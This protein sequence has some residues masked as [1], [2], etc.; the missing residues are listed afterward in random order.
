MDKTSC[1]NLGNLIST[2]LIII[3]VSLFSYSISISVF[4][5]LLSNLNMLISFM[6]L[7][8]SL[9]VFMSDPGY[10]TDLDLK[11]LLK[12]QSR[13]SGFSYN[14]CETC[15]VNKDD[16]TVHCTQCSKCVKG[17]HHHCAMLSNCIGSENKRIFKLL[18]VSAHV[19]AVIMIIQSVVGL[20]DGHWNFGYLLVI[21]VIIESYVCLVSFFNYLL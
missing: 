7:C 10:Y 4:P 13:M 8:F 15:K 20:L 16:S 19:W 18:T 5:V 3:T 12:Q 11:P 9:C 1:P 6:C 21:G 14:Y 2:I 17:F